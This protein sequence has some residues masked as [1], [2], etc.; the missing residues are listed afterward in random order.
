MRRT[1][2]ANS[3]VTATSLLRAREVEPQRRGLAEVDV[4]GLVARLAVA[5][6]EH[7]DH[8]R[9]GPRHRHLAGAP[10]WDGAG[11]HAACRGGRELRVEVLREGE[12]A[13]DEVLRRERVALEDRAHELLGRG[14]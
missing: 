9:E 4:L 7:P 14:E 5:V 12:D 10:Q 1:L 6:D 13:R 2:E 8:A 11:A 3:R